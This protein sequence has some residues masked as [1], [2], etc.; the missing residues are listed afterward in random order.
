ML[1]YRT[2]KRQSLSVMPRLGGI[3]GVAACSDFAWADLGC[4]D[5]F[6][7]VF[8][9]IQATDIT[10]D[11]EQFVAAVKAANCSDQLGHCSN[12]GDRNH[13]PDLCRLLHHGLGRY[14]GGAFLGFR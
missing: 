10:N 9:A 14:R 7:Q 2:V 8:H 1:S 4:S 6:Q 12:L 11:G 5:G 13:V 3:L